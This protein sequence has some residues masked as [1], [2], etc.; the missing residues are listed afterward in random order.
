MT[1]QSQTRVGSVAQE[2]ARL[3]D[4]MATMARSRSSSGQNPSRYAGRPAQEPVSPD[5]SPRGRLA[6]DPAAADTPE[7]T[8][9]GAPLEASCSHCGGESVGTPAAC[10]LCPLCQ[11][12]ALLRSVR[13]EIVDQLADVASVV[14]ECLRDVAAKSRATGPA[15]TDRPAS[16]SASGRGRATQD[17]PVDDESEG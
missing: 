2:A 6:D 17:I 8:P 16:G 3:I 11:G 15:S 14:A 7:G 9:T 12:I 10:R 5:A 1:E 4:D 13:P